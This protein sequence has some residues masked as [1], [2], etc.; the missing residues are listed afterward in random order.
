MSSLAAGVDAIEIER[1]RKTLRRHP[2]RFLRR[3]YTELEIAYCHGRTGELAVRFAAKEATM[4]ALGTGIRG[5]GWR[6]IEVLPDR[7]GK[8]LVYLHGKA[9]ER[10]RQIGMG[11]PEVSM[12]HSNLLA[13]AFV[14]APCSQSIDY[15]DARLALI[16]RLKRR[17]RL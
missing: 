6:D 14:V 5:V 16:E 15:E 13:I 3:I 10:A 9:S 11:Q 17:G 4:K 12:T 8:P 2:E 7:R 1:V